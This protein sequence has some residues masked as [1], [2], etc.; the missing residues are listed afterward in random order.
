MIAA[1]ASR[2]RAFGQVI[3]GDGKAAGGRYPPNSSGNG[4]DSHRCSILKFFTV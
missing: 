1:P 4:V 3:Q 2:K